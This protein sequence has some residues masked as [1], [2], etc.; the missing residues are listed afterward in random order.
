MN[1]SRHLVAMITL[2]GA[3]ICHAR[4]VSVGFGDHIPPYVLPESQSGLEVEVFRA[5]L[6]FH[7]HVMVPQYFPLKRVGDMFKLGKIDAAMW[8]SGTDLA[9]DGIYAEPAVVYDNVF[10]TRSDRHFTIRKPDD[11]KGHSVLAFQGALAGYPFWLSGVARSGGYREVNNQTMQSLALH[12]GECDV[13]FTDRYI[14]RYF[15]KLMLSEH[16]IN[17]APLQEHSVVQ[18]DPKVFRAIFRDPEIKRDYEDGLAHLKENGDYRALQLKYG[19]T[20]R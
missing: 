19:I 12:Q 10:I 20:P 2:F 18:P 16:R 9:D 4:E 14:F 15:T 8:D 1:M 11:L 7:G 6:A 5:A 13:V 17:P 3:T